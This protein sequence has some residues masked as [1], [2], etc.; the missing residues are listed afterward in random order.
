MSLVSSL[1][2][3][4]NMENS[5]KTRF[6]ALALGFLRTTTIEKGPNTHLPPYSDQYFLFQ[7]NFFFF[8]EV[9]DGPL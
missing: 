5:L 6:S 8:C 2:I 3:K 4:N 7:H 1:R 9:L